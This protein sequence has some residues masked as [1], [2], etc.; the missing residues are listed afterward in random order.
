LVSPSLTCGKGSVNKNLA[1][2]KPYH[3]CVFAP[4]IGCVINVVQVK[5]IYLDKHL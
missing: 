4:V 3:I 2:N 5:E 1:P